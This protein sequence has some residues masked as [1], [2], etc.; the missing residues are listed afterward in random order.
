MMSFH[1]N[2]TLYTYSQIDHLKRIDRIGYVLQDDVVF[3][4][5]TIKETL[6]YTALLRLPSTLNRKQKEDRAISII[7]ELDL[8]R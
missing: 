3:P 1:L 4:H 2:Q 5:L 8:E 7:A 6:T